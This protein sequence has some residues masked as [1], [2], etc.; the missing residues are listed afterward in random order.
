MTDY[1]NIPLP[2][3]NHLDDL[4]DREGVEIWWNSANAWLDGYAPRELWPV[5]SGRAKVWEVVEILESGA[6]G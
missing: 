5:Q 6:F 3:R 1:D 2:I 4:Y